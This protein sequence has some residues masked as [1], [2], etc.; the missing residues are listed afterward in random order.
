MFVKD[1]ESSNWLPSSLQ[2]LSGVINFTSSLL[3]LTA[4]RT[5]IQEDQQYDGFQDQLSKKC[6]ILLLKK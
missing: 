6:M 4:S 2:Y 3:N 5:D 1:D